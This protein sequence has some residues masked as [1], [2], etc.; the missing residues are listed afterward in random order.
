M[1]ESIDQIRNGEYLMCARGPVVTGTDQRGYFVSKPD[2]S[3]EGSLVQI[4]AISPPMMLVKIFPMPCGDPSHD[5][6]PYI[7]T[8][9]FDRM[10]WSRPP[11]RYIREYM[12]AANH[13][14]PAPSPRKLLVQRSVNGQQFNAMLE[15]IYRNGA[16]PDGMLERDDD[17][18]DLSPTDGR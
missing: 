9:Q 7:T 6:T 8:I 14:P 11:R 18:D 10:G 1:I 4:M 3:F 13:Q 15:D 16:R 17:D 2:R 12:K 5:H